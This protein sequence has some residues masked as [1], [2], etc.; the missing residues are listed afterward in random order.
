M[1][2]AGQATKGGM[3]TGEVGAAGRGRG[4]WGEGRGV[5]AMSVW[6]GKGDK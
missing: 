5:A 2:G 3:D 1:G 4:W 6:E